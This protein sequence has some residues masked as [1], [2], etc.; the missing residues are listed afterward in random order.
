MMRCSE[1]FD[2]LLVFLLSPEHLA[3]C[4]SSWAKM[5]PPKNFSSLQLQDLKILALSCRKV[6]SR[7]SPVA[8]KAG[9]LWFWGF[10]S[11]NTSINVKLLISLS[12]PCAQEKIMVTDNEWNLR[13][14]V[15]WLRPAA[16][17]FSPRPEGLTYRDG[18]LLH[19]R[20]PQDKI[21]RKKIMLWSI[22]SMDI[23]SKL[24]FSQHFRRGMKRKTLPEGHVWL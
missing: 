4:P 16:N 5:W 10:Q 14:V 8:S 12:W 3:G 15:L 6:L 2:F 7:H 13:L 21:F 1:D 19:S 18:H 20:T 22:F 23:K 9:V 17:V 11:V 24:G